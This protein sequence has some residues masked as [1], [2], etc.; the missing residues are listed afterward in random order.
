[1]L[2]E[3]TTWERRANL[4]GALAPFYPFS[5]LAPIYSSDQPVYMYTDNLGQLFSSIA[6]AISSDSSVAVMVTDSSGKWYVRPNQPGIVTFDL[7]FT[8][9]GPVSVYR[10]GMWRVTGIAP[11]SATMEPGQALNFENNTGFGG[12]W[13]VEDPAIGDIDPVTGLFTAL[14]SG[15]TSVYLMS[16]GTRIDQSGNIL[17]RVEP[18]SSSSSGCGCGTTSQPGDPYLPGP[19]DWARR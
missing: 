15:I 11:F 17:V 14:D 9:P 2:T 3:V 7:T 4:Y 5:G 13:F 18:V 10:T 19:P 8:I 6:G 16:G 1:M 12:T